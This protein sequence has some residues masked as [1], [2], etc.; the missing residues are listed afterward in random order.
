MTF[1]DKKQIVIPWIVKDNNYVLSCQDAYFKNNPSEKANL[2]VDDYENNTCTY[3]TSANS[4][5]YNTVKTR[6]IQ[7]TDLSMFL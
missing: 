5:A 4:K 6:K 1:E 7:T 3:D 2:L